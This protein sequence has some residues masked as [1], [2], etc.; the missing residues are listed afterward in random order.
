MDITVVFANII[1]WM[2][3][4]LPHYEMLEFDLWDNDNPISLTYCDRCG[5][6]LS[7]NKEKGV[8]LRW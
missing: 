5:T 3:G 7:W 2:F 6:T 4:H 1:C 8:W